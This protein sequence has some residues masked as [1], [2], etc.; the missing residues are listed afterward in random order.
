M[1]KILV[2]EDN[3]DL[4]EIYKTLFTANGFDVHVM[5]DGF[6][7]IVEV[8]DYKPDLVLLDIMMPNMN[9]VEFLK[10]FKQNTSLDIPIVVLSNV[11]DEEILKEAIKNGAKVTLAKSEYTGKILVDKIKT[12]L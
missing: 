6:K 2:V 8:V 11:S 7:G 10:T 3:Q 5:T 4:G 1:K 9:G 12:Y